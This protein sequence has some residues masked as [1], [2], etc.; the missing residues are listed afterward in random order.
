M[1]KRII[2]L[3]LGSIITLCSSALA[4]DSSE[5]NQLIK[6]VNT[7]KA[8]SANMQ[9]DLEGNAKSG[10]QL[11]GYAAFDWQKVEGSSS[12]FSGIKF[13]P[14]FHAK[15]N[16]IFQFEGELEF[17]V[18]EKGETVTELEYAAGT[19]FLNDYMG[20]QVGKFMS[21]VGQFVQNQHPSWI[22]KLPTTPLGF[23]HDGAAPTSNIGIALRGGLPK[24]FNLRSNYALFVANAPTFGTAADGDVI[25]NATGVTSSGDVAN[26]IGGRYAI[27][28]VGGME[29]G[30]SASAGEVSETLTSNAIVARDYSVVGADF[31]YNFDSIDIKAEY[32]SQKIGE[33]GASPLEGG[34]WQAFYTQI[35]Y[36]FS[37]V[38]IE[39]VL[40]Y[41][42]YHNPEINRNQIAIGL[43]YLFANNLIAKFA[44]E[45]NKDENANAVNS[46]ANNNKMLA[47][48]AFGF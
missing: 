2:S 37:S 25:I 43:N 26:N 8:Q 32:V 12:R 34:T 40:R 3:A 33:N 17:S 10:F 30:L 27:D 29:I 36:Q 47:Q 42:D 18:D 46:I 35:S 20:L 22:N 13:A 16:D 19:I 9:S 14:I 7:L 48:L 39:P 21:P 1:K 11:A 6:D 41:S 4:A 31:M 15:Y 24:M 44:Y 45:Y 5:I 23:G 38:A 28:P